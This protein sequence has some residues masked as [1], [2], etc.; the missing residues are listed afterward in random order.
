MAYPPKP[1]IRI[2]SILQ[3]K[4]EGGS[5]AASA[6][7]NVM[8]IKITG[9]IRG[10]SA[11]ELK[12]IERL[13][14]R[15]LDRSEI[16]SLDLAREVHNVAAHLRRKIG[17][18]ISRDGDVE[19]VFVGSKDLLYLPD[20]GRYRLGLGRLRRL[21]LVFSD[22]SSGAE[23][24]IPHDIFT[25]LEKL[26]LDAVVSVKV[27]GNK[28]IATYAYIT[29]SQDPSKPTVAT[30]NVPDLGALTLD[31]Q[32][33]ITA[34]E[35]ELSL[36]GEAREVS[37][38]AKAILVGVYGKGDT[39]ADSSI[40]ELSELARTAGV[41]VMAKVIQRREPDPKT[42]LGKG[43]LEEVVL[44]CLR[45]GADMIIFDSELRPSQWRAI[46]NATELKV[47]DRSMLILDIFA[48]RAR[49]SDGRLQVELAQLRYTL[50]RLVEKDAGLSRLTGGI[51]GRGPGETKLEIGR[52]RIRDRITELERKINKLSDER[53][54]R[55][56]RRE[57]SGVPLVSILGY[58]NVGKS[59]LFNALTSGDAL[60][61]NKLFA[62]L[63]PAQ[64]KLVL[65]YDEQ[66]RATGKF[67]TVVLSD[68]VGFI[69]KLPQELRNA[70]RTTLEELY[71]A[72]LLVHV[73]DASDPEIHDRKTAVES[74]L[75]EMKLQDVPMLLVLNKG[76]L[77]DVDTQQALAREFDALVVSAVKGEG[78][79]ELKSAIKANLEK[80]SLQ[81]SSPVA[82]LR[83]ALKM[84]VGNGHGSNE[85]T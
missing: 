57:D 22:L 13:G 43:K 20:L 67:D 14:T 76:D 63:D 37:G 55:R 60:V 6:P 66:G 40:A 53:G 30:E 54:L 16:V 69:R 83:G 49:S 71:H 51:G 70:F 46:T 41:K 85:I 2:I 15:R 42:L 29:A 32:E 77:L 18:I 36:K 39:H 12:S 31:F 1:N 19:E 62:T 10:L 58:T 28:T 21:R 27:Q 33:F 59:T 11:A 26:R 73:L 47:I 8:A 38:S 7:H 23:A 75:T 34:L 4:G 81:E 17:L 79:R 52:R 72:N 24:N 74:I 80:A 64:K 84:S 45:L 61:E 9:N 50:P 48:G 78:L 5:F 3:S 68:T 44:Q 35:E 82:A 25:D 56:K 65:S